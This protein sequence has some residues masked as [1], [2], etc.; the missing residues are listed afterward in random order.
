MGICEFIRNI[1]PSLSTAYESAI[2]ILPNLIDLISEPLKTIPAYSRIPIKMN[3][4]EAEI[5]ALCEK[6]R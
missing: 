5:I 1:S 6:M 4:T 3:V 2:L